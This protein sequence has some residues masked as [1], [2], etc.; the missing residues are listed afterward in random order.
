MRSQKKRKK[1]IHKIEVAVLLIIVMVGFL[2]FFR[3]P[4]ITGNVSVETKNQALDIEIANSQ[5]YILTTNTEYAYK[6]TSLRLSGEV[7]GDGVAEVYID[8]GQ[9]Q[10]ILVYSNKMGESPGLGVEAITGK[11][12]GRQRITALAVDEGREEINL[13]LDYVK[14]LPTPQ[15]EIA[16]NE[17]LKE[18]P[19]QYKCGETCF[20]D[21]YMQK[22][23]SYN[24][25][26]YVDEGTIL[27]LD[28]V[29][30]TVE[31]E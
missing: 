28:E 3:N 22:D 4:T 21:M 24:L 25:L 31:V 6:L 9:K 29:T 5:N 26:F 27:R 1:N 10:K 17:E 19:F 20:M 16:E 15:F 11:K 12:T 2:S 8:N 7:I 23:V 18:G 30:Y 13:I 14:N